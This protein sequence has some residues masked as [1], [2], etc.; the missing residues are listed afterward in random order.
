MTSPASRGGWR[1]VTC[2]QATSYTKSMISKSIGSNAWLT[3]DVRMGAA[4]R[5]QPQFQHGQATSQ[6]GRCA[7]QKKEC[8][9]CVFE[10]ELTLVGVWRIEIGGRLRSARSFIERES[11]TSRGSIKFMPLQDQ[12][13]PQWPPD[14]GTGL[15][16]PRSPRGFCFELMPRKLPAPWTAERIPGGYVVKNA[17]A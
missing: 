10:I 12:S 4:Y 9:G 8:C 6:D 14:H 2:Y 16:K 7:E 5:K 17:T 1:A 15:T 11:G 3:L 13:T